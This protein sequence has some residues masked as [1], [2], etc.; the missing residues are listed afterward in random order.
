MKALRL[1]FFLA[2]SV[3]VLGSAAQAQTTSTTLSV[4]SLSSPDWLTWHSNFPERATGRGSLVITDGQLVFTQRYNGGF[5]TFYIPVVDT[6]FLKANI[7]FPTTEAYMILFCQT[8]TVQVDATHWENRTCRFWSLS[9]NM[10]TVT[11]SPTPTPAPVVVVSTPTP[12]PVPVVVATP[13]P[14]P[15]PAPVVVVA[16]P[17]PRP[18]ATTIYNNIGSGPFKYYA[19]RTGA[20][21]I[22]VKG[23]QTSITMTYFRAVIPTSDIL[24]V[25]AAGYSGQSANVKVYCN[26]GFVWD[27]NWYLYASCRLS[28]FSFVQ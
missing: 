9:L 28:S 7:R 18:L 6:D 16:T 8:A 10:T 26:T 13:T 2:L 14:T 4:Q 21:Q 23:T 24:A 1:T 25:Q 15:T 17:A 12:T 22:S 27:R 5:K 3:L 11:V 20:A 19:S